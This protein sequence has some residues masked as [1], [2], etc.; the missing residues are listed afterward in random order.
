MSGRDRTETEGNGRK[1][2]DGDGVVTGRR[3]G[4]REKAARAGRY[5]AERKRSCQG[6]ANCESREA[7]AEREAAMRRAGGGKSARRAESEPRARG[8]GNGETGWIPPKRG[9]KCREGTVSTEG[10]SRKESKVVG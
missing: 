6:S 7:K 10:G 3:N 9:V 5:T 8:D 1:V 2:P 4:P